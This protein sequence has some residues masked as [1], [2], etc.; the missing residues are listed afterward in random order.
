MGSAYYHLGE[1]EKVIEC[2]V[3]ALNI[4]PKQSSAYA[5]IFE[6]QL[7]QNQPFDEALEAKYSE[8]FH[9][10][11]E[12]FIHYE[13]LKILQDVV[14]DKKVNV[15]EWKQK[16]HGV[17]LGGWGFDELDAWI[18]GMQENKVKTKLLEVLKVFKGH[19]V[20]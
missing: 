12:T 13:M 7:T 8:L 16:Y 3:K 6:L 17:G 18:D 14:N 15:E 10:K 19:K 20:P 4:N 9:N 11:K 2:Y 5:N 1:F